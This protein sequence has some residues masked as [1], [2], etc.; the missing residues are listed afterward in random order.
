MIRETLRLIAEGDRT[1]T[2]MGRTL[3]IS[4]D[5]MK[6][7]VRMLE[8]MG[9]IEAVDQGPP[10]GGSACACCSSANSCQDQQQGAGAIRSYQLTNKGQR[11]CS[12]RET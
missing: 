1:L 9:Y 4:P 12:H 3:G 5:E 11:A 8:H 10:P 2:E 7:R 6:G